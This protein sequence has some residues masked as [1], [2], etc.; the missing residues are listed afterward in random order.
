MV[1]TE[2]LSLRIETHVNWKKHIEQM[3][4]ELPGACYTIRSVVHISNINT[5][6]LIY[7]VYFHSVTK[8]GIIF[9]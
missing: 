3:I 6:K 2:F 9:W 1:N 5:L 7:C 4:P 8:C